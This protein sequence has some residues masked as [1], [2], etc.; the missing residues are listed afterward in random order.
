MAGRPK[1]RALMAIMDSFGEEQVLDWRV[2]GDSVRTIQHKMGIPAGR[3]FYKWLDAVEGRR[4][5]WEEATTQAAEAMADRPE[6]RMALLRDNE[7]G[8]LRDDVTREELQLVKME[9]DHDKWRA[10]VANPQFGDRKGGDVTVNLNVQHLEA[11]RQLG[12]ATMTP[13]ALPL[14][15]TTDVTEYEVVTDDEEDT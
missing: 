7:T 2:A 10:A 1:R 15:A 3:A 13:T 6:A 12:K 8:R 5:R 11:V 9:N 14:P 4:Q